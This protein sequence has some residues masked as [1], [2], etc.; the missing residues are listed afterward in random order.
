MCINNAKK[1]LRRIDEIVCALN[2][3]KSFQVHQHVD[4]FYY[5]EKRAELSLLIEE[6]EKLVERLAVVDRWIDVKYSEI[7]CRWKVDI[8]LLAKH[9]EQ[10]F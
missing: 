10:D 7:F 6:R 3:K 8:R 2:G 5:M 9:R 4:Q 1:L